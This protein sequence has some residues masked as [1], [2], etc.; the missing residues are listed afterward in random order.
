MIHTRY[1]ATNQPTKYVLANVDSPI[2]AARLKR[3][4]VL[5]SQETTG[6]WAPLLGGGHVVER[7][8]RR[9]KIDSKILRSIFGLSLQ[10][11]E[12]SLR[13]ASFLLLFG[14]A[15]RSIPNGEGEDKSDSGKFHGIL[16]GCWSVSRN[17]CDANR[18]NYKDFMMPGQY[19]YIFF[20]YLVSSHLWVKFLA[21]LRLMCHRM[22]VN[23]IYVTESFRVW[24]LLSL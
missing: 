11:L 13:S 3:G 17:F 10:S 22:D 1:E 23:L 18:C 19:R 20:G 9:C 8:L 2:K 14:I 21:K 7:V 15:S 24:H 4:L 6:F 5:F 16:L 12:F